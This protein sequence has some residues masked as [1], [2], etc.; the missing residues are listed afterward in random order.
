MQIAKHLKGI[1]ASENGW[2]TKRQD[3]ERA[4]LYVLWHWYV[5]AFSCEK[6]LQRNKAV[7]GF[8]SSRAIH[9]EVTYS[10][11]TNSFIVCLTGLL[12]T[13]ECLRAR[14]GQTIDQTL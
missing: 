4:S 12:V 5:G 3:D 9:L 7:W 10:L 1:R 8:L 2:P 6:W 13:E 11:D 14:C